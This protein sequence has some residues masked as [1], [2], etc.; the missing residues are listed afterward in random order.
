[1]AHE[2]DRSCITV[3]PLTYENIEE[4][5]AMR[6]DFQRV[7]AELHHRRLIQE[8]RQL[9]L[10]P[11][12]ILVSGSPPLP[13]IRS[14][15]PLMPVLSAS[16]QQ[17]L[18][19]LQMHQQSRLMEMSHRGSAML[20]SP[21]SPVTPLSPA[22]SELDDLAS[23]TSRP[24]LDSSRAS[25]DSSRPS[26][27]SSRASIESVGSSQQ[28][29]NWRGYRR[30]AGDIWPRVTMLDQNYQDPAYQ[31]QILSQYP[32]GIPVY[33]P[34]RHAQNAI[35]HQPMQ[36]PPGAEFWDPKFA[37][38]MPSEVLRRANF[39]DQTFKESQ[40]SLPQLQHLQQRPDYNQIQQH[41][42]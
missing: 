29:P 3:D 37:N 8:S 20:A 18:L 17:Q 19:Q 2:Y 25:S 42:Q 14:T 1:M 11:P 16:Q 4:V 5:M 23:L 24:S 30:A 38:K 36:L 41:E 32:N 10:Q 15:R 39:Q 13:S 33:I 22:L 7:T 28:A 34:P 21:I 26:S 27:D 31:K 6:R 9:Q 40:L 35:P 12:Q